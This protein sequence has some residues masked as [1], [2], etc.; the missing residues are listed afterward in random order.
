M[1]IMCFGRP[2]VARG[3]SPVRMYIL[4]T[5]GTLS[6]KKKKKIVPHERK[7]GTEG[8]VISTLSGY[9]TPPWLT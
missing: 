8:S 1:N 5:N 4:V 3:L 6:K 2:C 9:L 7:K